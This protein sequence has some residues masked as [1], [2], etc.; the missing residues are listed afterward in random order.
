MGGGSFLGVGLN[1]FY[2]P[3]LLFE[4][5]LELLSPDLFKKDD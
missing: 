1:E 2:D 5:S 4:D 3:L